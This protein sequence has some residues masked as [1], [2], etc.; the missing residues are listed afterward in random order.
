M[1]QSNSNCPKNPYLRP[2]ALILI[3]V[4]VSFAGLGR[5][6][7]EE[8]SAHGMLRWRVI[9]DPESRISLRVPF[10]YRVVDMYYPGVRRT[11]SVSGE[12]AAGLTPEEIQKLL[13]ER[14]QNLDKSKTKYDVEVKFRPTAELGDLA[15][16]DLGEAAGEIAGLKGDVSWSEFDYYE[17]STERPQGNSKWAPEGITALSGESSTH[18]ILALSYEQGIAVIL[19]TGPLYDHDNEYILNTVEVMAEKRKQLQTYRQ[20]VALRGMVVNHKGEIGKPARVKKVASDQAYDI[21]TGHYH[22]ISNV[23]GKAIHKYGAMMEVL[24]DAFIKT[25]MPEKIPVFKMEV[26]IWAEQGEMG[27]AAGKIGV[28][29]LSPGVLGFFSSS[30]L[31]IMA[32]ETNRSDIDFST[33]A[34]LAHEASH[35]FLHMACNGSRHVPT[36]LNEGL[37]VYFE[38]ALY[39]SGRLSLRP[40]KGRL[41]S[42]SSYYSYQ[43]GGKMIWKP[44]FYLSHYGGI[45]GLNYGEVYLKTHFW[46]FG[47]KG[48]RERFQK[49]WKAL[50]KGEDGTEAF[51]RIFMADLIEKFG[52]RGA[53]LDK[54]EEL[55]VRHIKNIR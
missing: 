6:G 15:A 19:C 45:P 49:Y 50:L 29:P 8:L 48:G 44:D 39:R 32:Y 25:Y 16:K 22:V 35:Q 33:F 2:I 5:I 38:S 4:V 30:L 46:I 1:Y 52:T 40:P 18:S 55:V 20:G 36:W 24:Y 23:G 31:N 28:G 37:A 17:E 51:D 9:A 54:V 26:A 12:E 3:M 47:V 7:A 43:T 21:E 14:L 13:R 10:D 11:A 53:A 42:L 41:N 34:T 27:Q